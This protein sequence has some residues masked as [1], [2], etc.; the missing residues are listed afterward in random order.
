MRRALVPLIPFVLLLAGAPAAG[1]KVYC[2]TP[3]TGCADGNFATVQ[4]ALDQAK[5]N[6]GPDEV[7]L[8]ATTYT[9]SGGF[10]YD[11][12]GSASNAVQIFG[13]GR[14]ATTLERSTNGT[15]LQMAGNA[16]N[17]VTDL[18]FHIT[19]TDLS[20]G[21]L[22][23]SA[24]VLRVDVDA[25]A[26]VGNCEALQLAPGSARD[27]RVS[28]P[29]AGNTFG[30]V[31]GGPSASDGVFDST[32]VADKGV[33]LGGGSMQHTQVTGRQYAITA[34]SGRIDDV[35]ARITGS[36]AL[37]V[38]LDATNP[39]GGNSS[40]T[41]RHLTILGDGG[42]S[43]TGILVFAD[44]TFSSG[45]ETVDLRSS[46]VRG[47]ANSFNR[48]GSNSGGNTGTADLSIS[49]TDYDPATSE[50]SGPGTGPNL[51][52]PTNPNVDPQFVDQANGDLRLR[53]GSPLIDAGDPAAPIGTEPTTDAAGNPR[54]V[55][56][57]GDGTVRRD[58]GA[59]E[60][61]RRAP[62]V[63][64]E[65]PAPIG[66]PVRVPITFSATATDPDGDLLT[67]AWTFDDG[68]SAPGATVQ[69]AF[70][71]QG[72]H[73]ATI[74]VTDSAGVSSSS[75]VA[76]GV[77]PDPRTIL[78]A[79]SVHPA[80]FRLKTGTDIRFALKL[81]ASV[82]F[83]VDRAAAG[84]KL[85]GRCVRPTKKNRSAKKCKRHVLLAGFFKRSGAAGSNH[86]HW[87]GR[88]KGK[89]LKPGSYRL[90]AT[91]GSGRTA[92]VRRASFTV[93]R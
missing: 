40:L 87:N 93:K 3:A 14:A 15:I 35:V 13:A 55:D 62:I 34:S 69:H 91:V 56:G 45:T 11:D 19:G 20:H 31:A 51:V 73:V 37:R 28:M 82:K 38:G 50:Q 10:T 32:V 88:L 83:T 27:V 81:P 53:G 9:S 42:P 63:T 68:G 17:T 90:I 18:R 43:S 24:D 74:T 86:S 25:D 52:D 1:A 30:I 2:V 72:I 29:A 79:L 23:G 77:P 57:N 59:L 16:R 6:V 4:A 46:I 36:A 60:Y 44:S 8:G 47:V 67:Y 48:L 70:A 89:A 5:G 66:A 61:Q 80:K 71:T 84:R 41:V 65:V 58:I 85:N 76:V 92:S 49:Y 21:L 64:P 54:V 75:Q 39:V 33:T 78:S 22:G 7:H 12:A 26:G